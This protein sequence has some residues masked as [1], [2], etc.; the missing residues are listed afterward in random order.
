MEFADTRFMAGKPYRD[1]VIKGVSYSQTPLPFFTAESFISLEDD[2]KVAEVTPSSGSVAKPA[3]VRRFTFLLLRLIGIPFLLRELIQRKWVT[4]LCWH[5]P[6]PEMMADHI[7]RLQRH[8]NIISLRQYIEWRQ[9]RSEVAIPPKALV[10]TLDDGHL[11]NYYLEPVVRSMAVPITIFLCSAIVG[12][13]RHYW[14]T[15]VSSANEIEILKRI[16]DDQR[17]A[18]L[19]VFGFDEYREHNERQALSS[20]EITV[21]KSAMDFQA[22]TRLHPVLPM[23]PDERVHDEIDNCK[24]ELERDFG[25]EIYAFAY[26]NGDYSDRDVEAVRSAGFQCALTLDGGFNTSKTDPFRLRR[27]P[28][29]DAANSNELIVK[30][31]G[32]WDFILT[33]LGRRAYGHHARPTLATIGDV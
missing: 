23:C 11:G 15:A 18:R 26:P 12:T 31:S 2:N 20:E 25:L 19:S 9:G 27:I 22:H 21:L 16:P 3:R 17:R 29:D 4:I 6:T 8:Y 7:H 32:L 13:H 5:N 1:Y 24:I 30:A 10:I 28:V 14:W 33:V